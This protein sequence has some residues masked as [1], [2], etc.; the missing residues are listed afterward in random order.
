MKYFYLEPEVAGGLGPGTLMDTSTHP[1][2]ISKLNYQ[3]DDWLGDALLETF[4]CFIITQEGRR[5][6]EEQRFTGV[7]FEDVEITK[8]DLF[9]DLCSDRSLPEFN[10]LRVLGRAA[11]D[12]FGISID[13][14]LVV[15][16]R[17]LEILKKLG[18]SNA[19]VHD[20]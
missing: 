17:V 10:W 12:D 20:F 19:L 3:F 14:R 8:S 15:S 2:K 5:V 13:H 16:E 11:E 4:P 1:P 18:I 6:I 9:Q 7:R